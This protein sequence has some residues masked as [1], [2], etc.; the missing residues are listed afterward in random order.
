V[1]NSFHFADIPSFLFTAAT[2]NQQAK[3]QSSDAPTTGLYDGGSAYYAAD[4][5][6][7]IALAAAGA[8]AGAGDA[9]AITAAAAAAAAP[10]DPNNPDAMF[11]AARKRI[12]LDVSTLWSSRG[13]LRGARIPPRH[14]HVGCYTSA[15]A[16][17]SIKTIGCLQFYFSFCTVVTLDTP[18]TT[19]ADEG[20]VLNP[21]RAASLHRNRPAPPIPTAETPLDAAGAESEVGA[22]GYMPMAHIP[23]EPARA[24]HNAEAGHSVVNAQSNI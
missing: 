16:R 1:P 24:R 10:V 3:E 11:T 7:G 8:G 4:D 12:L 20:M 17:A 5:T 18:P 22:A 21:L 15:H 6:P 19:Q 13:V 2:R 9:D 14:A 23:Q